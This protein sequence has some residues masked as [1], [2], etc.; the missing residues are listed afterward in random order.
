MKTRYFTTALV[1][2]LIL[3]TSLPSQAKAIASDEYQAVIDTAYRYF[4]GAANGDQKLLANSF[5]MEYGHIKMLR[6]DEETGKETI[7]TMTLNEFAKVFK[8]ATKDTWQAEVLTVDIVKNKMAMVKLNFDTPKTNYIDYL[9]MHK[10]NGQWR[11]VN[12]TF[13]AEKKNQ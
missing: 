3:L 11:I 1:S 5:D 4:E 6:E 12:K 9:V 13:V 7:K 8:Q 10:R 2:A